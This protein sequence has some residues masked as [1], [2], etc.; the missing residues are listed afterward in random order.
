MIYTL[1]NVHP[2]YRILDETIIDQNNILHIQA[3]SD[4]DLPRFQFLKKFSPQTNLFY[5]EIDSKLDRENKR[6]SLYIKPIH[7]NY[8]K[9]NGEF[10][11]DDDNI[12]EHEFNIDYH[13]SI[14]A[15]SILLHSRL[16]KL[17]LEQIRQDF[18]ILYSKLFSEKI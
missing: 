5:I 9:F 17:I 16:K 18:K 7:H 12:F 3:K 13:Y 10:S 15:I 4:V 8:F 14:R 2:A 6:F 11:Y 1:K